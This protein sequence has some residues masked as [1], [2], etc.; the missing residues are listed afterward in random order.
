MVHE[1]VT[2]HRTPPPPPA[3][4]VAFAGCDYL[5]LAHH[6]ALLHALRDGAETH[7]LTSSA[8]RTTT[9]NTSVHEELDRA[10]ARWTRHEAAL[11]VPDGLIAN[12][13]A[14]Q[15]AH[16]RG[17]THAWIAPGSHRSLEIAVRAAGLHRIEQPSPPADLNTPCLLCTDAVFTATGE[18]AD[19]PTLLE[20]LPTPDS[21]LLID[22]CH[23]FPVLGAGRG[24]RA[25]LALDDTRIWT[26]TSLAK[27]LGAGGGALLAP[28]DVIDTAWEHADAFICTTP[29]SPAIASAALAALDLIQRE[30]DRVE[31]LAD[32]SHTLAVRLQVLGFGTHE[33]R[34]PVFALPLDEASA[35]EFRRVTGEHAVS[36]PIMAYPGGPSV[37]YARISLNASHTIADLDRLCAALKEWHH[38]TR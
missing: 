25:E 30:P 12:I 1:S 10:L 5:S 9:G 36:V 31:R 14:C 3:Q 35:P 33:A 29:P 4:A 23:G 2:T 21:V 34:T 28:Q 27:G 32:L 26:T 16:A 7:G 24:T 19:L 37:L 38:D 17:V 13:A 11:V 20:R 6:P 18:V 8:S 22:D 15:T